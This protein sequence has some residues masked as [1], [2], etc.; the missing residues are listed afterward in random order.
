MR[1]TIT[2]RTVDALAPRDRG[3]VVL[4]D[5]EVRG[6]GIRARVGGAKT[7]RNGA[8]NPTMQTD[9]WQARVALDA[10]YGAPRGKAAVGCD[11]VRRDPA[12][13]P[14]PGRGLRDR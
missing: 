3:E 1:G 14:T 5:Q 6:F 12:E 2:K 11:R 9:H 10:R 8:W 7:Y 4:G 13:H